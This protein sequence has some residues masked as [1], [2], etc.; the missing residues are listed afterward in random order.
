MLDHLVYATP[1]LAA[2]VAELAARGVATVPGGPHVGRGTRNHLA[3]LGDGAYL[4]VIGPDPEQ[5]APPGPRP[6]GVDALDAA[7]L[8][9]W[10][11][12]PLRP[13]DEVVVAARAA[14]YDPG[15]IGEMSRRRPDGLLLSWR[16]TLAPPGGALPFLIDW[17]ASPHP[18]TSLSDG[19]TLERFC[20]RHP[21]IDSIGSVLR[22]IGEEPGVPQLSV[23]PAQL[24]ATLRTADGS[25]VEL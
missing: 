10:C 23:G 20:V 4:E 22:A 12:R 13:L 21:D 15:E 14:G 3:S 25:L 16:L 1:S 11:A 6:F 17:L 9:A 7:A 2:T 24:S 19:V 5:P 18:S 8:V